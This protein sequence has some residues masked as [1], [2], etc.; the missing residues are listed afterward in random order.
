MAAAIGR[1]DEYAREE[2][3]SCSSTY[4]TRNDSH[5]ICDQE[6]VGLIVVG[7]RSALSIPKLLACGQSGP[8]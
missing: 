3:D 4:T 1:R 2:E 5:C 8:F 6:Y 7:R